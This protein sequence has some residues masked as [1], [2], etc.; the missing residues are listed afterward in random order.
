VV[1]PGSLRGGLV[2]GGRGERELLDPAAVRG[3]L[4]GAMDE[5]VR[6][7]GGGLGE[8]VLAMGATAFDRIMEEEM[9]AAGRVESKEGVWLQFWRPVEVIARDDKDGALDTGYWVRRVSPETD[10]DPMGL[11]LSL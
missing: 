11:S 3:C 5:V 4:L 9:A 1:V 7:F 2:H 6:G 10:S 8:C